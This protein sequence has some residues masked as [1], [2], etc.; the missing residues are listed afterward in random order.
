MTRH[1]RVIFLAFYAVSIICFV[2][3]TMSF[4]SLDLVGTPAPLGAY[5][6]VVLNIGIFAATDMAIMRLQRLVQ[7]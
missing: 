5:I 4:L 3:E 7:K 1:L 6:L 2:I